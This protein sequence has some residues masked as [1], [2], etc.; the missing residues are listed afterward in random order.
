MKLIGP[1]SFVQQGG[2]GLLRS[3]RLLHAPNRAQTI[4]DTVLQ[5]A[6]PSCILVTAPDLG[7]IKP[8]NFRTRGGTLRAGG[9]RARLF[10]EVQ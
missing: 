10:V 1:F 7:P 3:R 6:Q 8:T 4:P 9:R 2:E 5:A